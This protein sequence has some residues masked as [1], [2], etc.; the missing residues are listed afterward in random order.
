M[1][2]ADARLRGTACIKGNGERRKALRDLVR[3]APVRIT[4]DGEYVSELGPHAVTY[5]ESRRHKAERIRIRHRAGI[6]LSSG[7]GR[8]QEA[9]RR[10]DQ[11]KRNAGKRA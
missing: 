6:R 11:A 8:D 2:R 9:R 3:Y 1:T 10:N 7:C 4:R 5:G